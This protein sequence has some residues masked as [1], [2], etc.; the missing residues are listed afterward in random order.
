MNITIDVDKLRS[1]LIEYY[2]TAKG[3]IREATGDL[4]KVETASD[5]E[6]VDIAMS[7]GI[8]LYNYQVK[9]RIRNDFRHR[10]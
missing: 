5:R 9:E 6:L 2:G 3:E 4:I 10:W 7:N 1:D 8:N